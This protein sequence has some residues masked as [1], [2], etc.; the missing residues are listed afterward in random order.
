M[1]L[2]SEDARVLAVSVSVSVSVS[3]VR[4]R[5]LRE[6]LRELESSAQMQSYAAASTRVALI[7]HFCFHCML[8]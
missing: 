6:Q 8:I 2:A 3:A 4:G 7:K 5:G 1:Q